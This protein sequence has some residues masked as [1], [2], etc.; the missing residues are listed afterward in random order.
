LA[1]HELPHISSAF[2]LLYPCLFVKSVILGLGVF[3]LALALAWI[4]L[5]SCCHGLAGALAAVDAA[6][7]S[8]ISSV[9]ESNLEPSLS[10]LLNSSI[11]VA[12]LVNQRLAFWAALIVPRLNSKATALVS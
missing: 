1:L 3:E 10:L 6:F 5:K 4:F 9:F 12:V 8:S 2:A 11:V 7:A